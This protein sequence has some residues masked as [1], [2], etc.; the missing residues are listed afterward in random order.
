MNH[1][2]PLGTLGE[3]TTIGVALEIICPGQINTRSSYKKIWNWKICIS[4]IQE[5]TYTEN[6][7]KSGQFM[8]SLWGAV[9]GQC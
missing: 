1:Q 5:G 3:L 6:N 2:G 4:Y 9:H 8:I 7:D